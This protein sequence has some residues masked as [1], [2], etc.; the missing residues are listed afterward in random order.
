LTFGLD[1]NLGCENLASVTIGEDNAYDSSD[2]DGWYEVGPANCT[3]HAP[4][5]DAANAF[6]TDVITP[7][8]ADKWTVV[9]S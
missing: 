1:W 3:L 2:D 9:N 6:K 7:A 5:Q 4:T 8:Y